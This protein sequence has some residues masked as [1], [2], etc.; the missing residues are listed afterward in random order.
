MSFIL[1]FL[2][3]DYLTAS[4]NTNLQITIT[5]TIPSKKKETT[6]TIISFSPLECVQKYGVHARKLRSNV[7]RFLPT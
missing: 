2:N 4:I 3:S 5:T 7:K 6:T 1:F